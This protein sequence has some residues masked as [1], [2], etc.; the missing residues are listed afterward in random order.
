MHAELKHTARVL[1]HSSNWP[2]KIRLSRGRRFVSV[3]GCGCIGPGTGSGVRVGACTA[4]P[5]H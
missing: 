3:P 2:A 5:E 1:A 4:I